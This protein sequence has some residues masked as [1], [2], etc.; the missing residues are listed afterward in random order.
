MGGKVKLATADSAR[1]LGTGKSDQSLQLDGYQILG[2]NTLM[3]TVG[4]KWMGKPDGSQFR[5]A[6]FASLGL[7]RQLSDT[8]SVGG[9]LD[10][11][12]SVVASRSD[13]VEFTLYALRNVDKHWRLQA[14]LYGGSNSASPDVG[15]GA[16]VNYRY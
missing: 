12:R 6:P 13:Q 4:Y 14:Y 7:S 8:V 16:S 1:G 11:R 10:W 15:G 9:I 3:G 2:Q 5:D